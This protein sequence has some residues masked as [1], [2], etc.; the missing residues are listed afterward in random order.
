MVISKNNMESIHDNT[1]IPNDAQQIDS[2]SEETYTPEAID[3]AAIYARISG[4]GNSN[5]IA[6]Q[7]EL[8]KDLLFEKKLVLY[9]VYTDEE[10]ATKLP[11]HERPG[12]KKLLAD[13]RLG[14]FKTVIAFRR[15]RLARN[16]EDFKEI[17]AQSLRESLIHGLA[18]HR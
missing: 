1:S 16:F 12:F 4:K 13:A 6:T 8:A 10:S 11:F 2:E 18:T 5:S 17:K 15:D 9:E 7:I 3:M 14:N